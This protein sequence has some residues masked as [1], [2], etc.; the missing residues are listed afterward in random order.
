MLVDDERNLYERIVAF[1]IVGLKKSIPYIIK[2]SPEVTINGSW[3]STEICGCI[4]SL[5]KAGFNLQGVLL[6]TIPAM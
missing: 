4:S 5:S 6:I 2:A 1:M 3:L